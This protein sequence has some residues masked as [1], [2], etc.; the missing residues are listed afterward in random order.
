MMIDGMRIGINFDDTLTDTN[1]S[2]I[3]VIN[4][5]RSR[6]NQIDFEEFDKSECASIWRYPG[7][8]LRERILRH[9]HGGNLLNDI[10]VVPMAVMCIQ[11]VIDAGVEIHILTS[12]TE[13]ER[14]DLIAFL[15][16]HRIR[17]SE[18][19]IHMNLG[20]TE[21]IKLCVEKKLDF[22]VEDNPSTISL[23]IRAGVM[24]V[25]RDQVYNRNYKNVLRMECFSQLE[26]TCERALLKRARMDTRNAMKLTEK[27]T[28]H[29]YGDGFVETFGVDSTAGV[30]SGL[31]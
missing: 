12:R 23:G 27:L 31:E 17:V 19:N 29:T 11:E 15:R 18:D 24:M 5:G 4:Q 9:V 26:E 13:D 10:D 16:R 21:K 22:Y 25:V 20:N 6:S 2:M 7:L 14:I 30:L 1:Y 8:T 3:D 28:L